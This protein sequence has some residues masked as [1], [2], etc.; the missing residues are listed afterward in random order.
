MYSTKLRIIHELCF[1]HRLLNRLILFLDSFYKSLSF[2]I[3][4][5]SILVIEPCGSLTTVQSC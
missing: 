4:S 1:I 5:H 2:M 3:W